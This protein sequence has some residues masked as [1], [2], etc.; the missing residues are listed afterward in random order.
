MVRV[1]VCGITNLEDALVAVAAGADALGF[2]FWPGSP[3]YIAPERAKEIVTHLPPFVTTVGVFVNDK[4]PRVEQMAHRTGI[5]TAQLHGEEPPAQ[6][7]ALAAA[8]L[9]VLKALRVGRTFKPRCLRDYP[10]A[11]AFLLDA[12]VKGRRGGTGKTFDWT[13]ARQASRY[14]RILLAG[15]LTVEN[16]EEAIRRAQ[17]Y[18]VDVCS[19][20]EKKPG[21]KDHERLRAFLRRA[22]AAPCA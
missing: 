15:G 20:V 6:V 17:P 3:R 18:G 19:G 5:R 21:W 22:K 9:A 2:N 7:A 11:T 16:V 10:G 4:A 1:K 13:S 12:E 8:G 14:G